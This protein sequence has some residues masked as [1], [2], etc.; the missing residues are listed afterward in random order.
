MVRIPKLIP[1]RRA[2][3]SAPMTT[4]QWEPRSGGKVNMGRVNW[5]MRACGIFVLW[6][7]AAVNLPAQTFT[8]L[9]SF[10]DYKHGYGPQVLIQATDGNLY[11]TTI[12]GGPNR[13]GTIF[14]ITPSG[15]LATLYSFDDHPRDGAFPF[16]LVQATNGDFYGTTQ[17]G[18]SN[19]YYGTVFKITPSGKLTTL[20]SFDDTD[21]EYPNGLVQATNG[22]F[23]GTT[24]A[25]G[26]NDDGTVFKITPSGS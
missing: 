6:A 14:K 5:G 13:Y 7:T 17:V 2:L 4:E 24:I 25:G 20:Y 18:G 26:V 9:Y 15:K 12:D 22:T 1:L 10:D 8:T 11:G 16:N 21:G 19:I 3:T 23:Y